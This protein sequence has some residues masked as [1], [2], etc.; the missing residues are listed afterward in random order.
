MRTGGGRSW[1]RRA[2][3]DIILN[4]VMRDISELTSDIL[5]DWGDM[6]TKFGYNELCAIRKP[7]SRKETEKVIR[8]CCLR[9]IITRGVKR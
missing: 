7:T 5:P 4:S 2:G 1:N 6:R 3:M 8:S 9:R